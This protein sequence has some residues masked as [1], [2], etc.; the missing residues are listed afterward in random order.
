MASFFDTGAS[1]INPLVEMWNEFVDI[2]PGLFWAVVLVIIGWFV[3]K[4]FGHL[5]ER[6]LVKLKLDEHVKKAGLT[7]AFGHIEL[8]HLSGL[9]LKWYLFVVFLGDAV[10]LLKLG[11][12]SLLLGSFLFWLPNVIIAMIIMILGLLLADFV[13]DRLEKTKIR[14]VRIIS[15]LV[16]AGILFFVTIMAFKQVGLYVAIAE[17]TF[18][19]LLSGVSLALALAVGIGFGL[20]LKD[21]AKGIIKGLKKKL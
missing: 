6:V 18:I 21:E 12:L 7:D 19:I 20:A 13:A 17:T 9:I 4:F 11:T 3:A 1:M 8:S 15:V 2:L 16:K 5:L 10:S 14:S